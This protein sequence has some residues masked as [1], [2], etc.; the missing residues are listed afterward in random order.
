[1]LVACQNSKKE[2]PHTCC[3]SRFPFSWDVVLH[4]QVIGTQSFA[5][6]YRSLLQN[7]PR[8]MHP[9]YNLWL[10]K[11]RTLCCLKIFDL[12]H[13]TMQI[14]QYHGKGTHLNTREEYY[15]YA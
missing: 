3:F 6:M 15:I 14:L 13:N 8:R 12:I 11:I 9:S 2:S 4:H 10:L 7:N 5:T 1:M